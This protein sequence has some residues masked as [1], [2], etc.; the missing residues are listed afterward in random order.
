MLQ[1][2]TPIGL[3]FCGEGTAPDYC[4]RAAQV[5]GVIFAGVMIVSQAFKG[6]A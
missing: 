1:K 6:L 2:L 5:V 3:W 4:F